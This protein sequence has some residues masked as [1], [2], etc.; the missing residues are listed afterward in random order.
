MLIAVVNLSACNKKAHTEDGNGRPISLAKV[1]DV[2][3]TM[4]Q[5]AVDAVSANDWKM[6]GNAV[7]D[8]K[9]LEMLIDRQLLQEEAMHHNLD[10]DPKV[11]QEIDRAKGQIL[12]QA[13]LQS[14]F[15][16]IGSP[17]EG[18]VNAYFLEHPE[19]FSDRKLFSVKELVVATKDFNVQL[20]SRVDSANS[21]EQVAAWLDKNNVQYERGKL[22]RNTAGLAPEMIENL[23]AM[24]KN[25][26]FV[27]ETGE[28]TMLDFLYDVKPSP[29]TADAAAPQ[30]AL[31]LRNKK[32]KEIGDVELRR[33]RALATIEYF[34]KKQSAP[35]TSQSADLAGSATTM[36]IDNGS[37]GPK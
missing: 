2:E 14:K 10:R 11:M 4:Q 20:K 23:K 19:L 18:E 32:R 16:A 22:S 35:T 8:Q 5:P 33:L 36:H 12:A 30:I 24:R 37:T 28:Y 21:I 25:R 15:V 7:V 27:V 3:I 6:D 34:G 9:V 26:I 29:V 31:F 17:S 13:Y 1:N